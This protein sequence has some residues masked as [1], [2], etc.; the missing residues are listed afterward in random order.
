MDDST[1]P[2]YSLPDPAIRCLAQ[3][4]GRKPALLSKDDARAEK[5][6]TTL[7][8]RHF[9]IGCWQGQPV[10]YDLLQPRGPV[11][12]PLLEMLPWTAQQKAGARRLAKGSD[13]RRLRLK[14]CVGWLL[15]DPA[16][17]KETKELADQWRALPASERPGF[18]LGR[19]FPLPVGVA[20]AR[21]SPV[22]AAF[23]PR[24]KAFLDRWGLAGMATW[25]LPQPQGPLL[26]NLLPPGAPALPAHGVHLMLPLHYPLQGDDDLLRQIFNLQRQAARDLGLSESLAGLPHFKAYASL[27]DVF[28]LERAV[29][30][31]LKPRPVPTG[32]L[33]QLEEAISNGMNYSLAQVQKHR[34]AIKRCKKGQRSHISRLRPR[35]R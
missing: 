10:R 28:H 35:N 31:R 13:E 14:G 29:W 3:P 12:E 30:A 20:A 4:R 26:P 6:F 27:F 8:R 9:A 25:D 24:L 22:Q 7:C 19:P 32:F 21:A 11:P 34:A 16:F 1:D 2:V 5:E 15:T 17:E 23:G 18:P 33:G